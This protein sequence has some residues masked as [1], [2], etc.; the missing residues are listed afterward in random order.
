MFL[1]YKKI[2]NVLRGCGLFFTIWPRKVDGGRFW[3][4]WYAIVWWVNVLNSGATIPSSALAAYYYRADLVNMMKSL[5]EL[6]YLFEACFNFIYC[7][8]KVSNWEV[9]IAQ[10]YLLFKYD[11]MD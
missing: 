5:V 1:D 10:G 6:T 3:D 11:F 9:R 4:F 2:F 8:V 7:K